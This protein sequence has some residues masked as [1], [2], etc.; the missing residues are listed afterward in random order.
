M[1]LFEAMESKNT[2]VRQ[3]DISGDQHTFHSLPK[4]FQAWHNTQYMLEKRVEIDNSTVPDSLLNAYMW[5]SIND[6]S[7]YAIPT[8]L[9]LIFVVIKLKIS[10]D[11]WGLLVGM[12]F[13]LPWLIYLA[14]HFLFY[15]K[16]KAQTVGPVTIKCAKFT[17]DTF[18]STFFAIFGSLTIAFTFV[19]SIMEDLAELLYKII[20]T[21]E[22]PDDMV[23]QG[24]KHYSIKVYNFMVDLVSTT[25][26]DL[27][28][29]ILSNTYFSVTLVFSMTIA[30]IFI[31]ERQ[32]Y[33]ERKEG[34]EAELKREEIIK[35]YPIDAALMVLH[36]WREDNGV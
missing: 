1:D 34:V 17:A 2:S 6:A 4:E 14:Y 24:V 3:E 36:E 30:T 33:T 16:I 13:Y 5:K 9:G 11:I 29:R 15:A 8:T 22:A 7:K 32:S 20:L 23:S 35:G 12:A 10:P 25:G 27:F 19:M 26:D 31:F 28:S 21:M 18:Y